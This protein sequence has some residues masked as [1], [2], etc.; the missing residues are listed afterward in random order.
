MVIILWKQ[1]LIMNETLCTAFFLYQH[2]VVST[3]CLVGVGQFINTGL[4][5]FI[6]LKNTFE[7]YEYL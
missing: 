5:S 6:H 2:W 7:T 1:K 3:A 4:D